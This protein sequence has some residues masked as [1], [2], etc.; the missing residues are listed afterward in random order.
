MARAL[1]ALAGV[2]L[3]AAPLVIPR[4]HVTL[5]LPAFAYGIGLLGLNLLFGTTGLLS[6]GHAL[7]VA[8]GAYTAAVLTSRA[9]V[10][11]LEAILV[12]AALAAAVVAIPVGLL[13]VRYVRIYFGMLTLAFGMLFYSFLYKFY[14]LTGGDEG[15][16]V[17]R[18]R[19]L[20]HAF[21]GLDKVEFLV[22]PFYYYALALLA[23]AALVMRRIVRS[24]FGLS[25]RAIRENPDKAAYVGVA[26]R[27]YRFY[28]FVLAAV[29]GAVGGALLAVPTGLADPLLAYWTHSGNLVFM[30]L[31]GGFDHF[32]G[33]VVGALVFILLQDT[34]MSL[35]A[36]WR[37][38]FGAILAVIVIFFPRGLLGLLAPGREPA[39]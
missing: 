11:D 36:Y 20:G 29:F 19:L 35:T 34:V 2:A 25:L 23:V 38:V 22:G 37:F 5:L 24:P 13:C 31:L 14:A 30:L 8:L 21:G 6:F 39:A 33:P 12:T 32:L 15:I 16:R 28:A 10:L 1:G 9:G 7:F 26:V 3:L 18:P 17:L 27:R 4:Y